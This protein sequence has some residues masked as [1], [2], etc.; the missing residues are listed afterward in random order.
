ME[1]IYGAVSNDIPSIILNTKNDEDLSQADISISQR[2][3]KF[4]DK[5]TKRCKNYK[6][7]PQSM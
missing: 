4:L 7:Y 5:P 2:D 1:L 3:V 6:T